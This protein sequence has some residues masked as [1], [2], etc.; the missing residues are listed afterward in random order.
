[1]TAFA[2]S[3]WGGFFGG[4]LATVVV[5]FLGIARNYV[6]VSPALWALGITGTPTRVVGQ[7]DGGRPLSTMFPLKEVTA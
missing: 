3:W 7:F 6:A 5:A 2:L 4:V 1:M